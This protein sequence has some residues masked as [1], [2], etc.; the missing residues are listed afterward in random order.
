MRLEIRRR[1]VKLT[2]GLRTYLKERLRPALAHF[3]RHVEVVRVYLRDMNGPRGGLGKKCRIVVE[4]PPRGNRLVN[5]PDP[6]SFASKI[7]L[8]VNSLLHFGR[9]SASRVRRISRMQHHRIACLTEY[10]CNGCADTGSGSCHQR[11][12]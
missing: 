2:E 10:T 5:K 4:L 1:G 6:V 11:N 9:H 3:G 7:R 12:A 8:H